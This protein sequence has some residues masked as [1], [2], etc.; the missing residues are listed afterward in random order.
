MIHVRQRAIESYITKQYLGCVSDLLDQYGVE[1][2]DYD[3]KLTAQYNS[4]T[5]NE[6]TNIY[7][8]SCVEPNF[9]TKKRVERCLGATIV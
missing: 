8:F 6:L 2:L 4:D 1:V 7:R 5:D 3:T 9:E